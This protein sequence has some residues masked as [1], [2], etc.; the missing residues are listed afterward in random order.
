MDSCISKII[1]DLSKMLISY[2]CVII[3]SSL[4]AFWREIDGSK[5]SVVKLT[6]WK[7]RD[8]TLAQ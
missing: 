1:V 5:F 6:V 3:C 8:L 2:A 7:P 4:G